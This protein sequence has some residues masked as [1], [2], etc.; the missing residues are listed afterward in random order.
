MAAA[1]NWNE[2]L[3]GSEKENFVGTMLKCATLIAQ[4]FENA[5]M[6]EKKG[7]DVGII[8]GYWHSYSFSDFCLYLGVP[9]R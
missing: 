1:K 7:P 4:I 9:I 2:I 6:F 3:F 5:N 8:Y